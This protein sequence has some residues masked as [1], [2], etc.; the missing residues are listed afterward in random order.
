[1]CEL[2]VLAVVWDCL[3]IGSLILIEASLNPFEFQFQ[4]MKMST[5]EPEILLGHCM[6]SNLPYHICQS[7]PS[8]QPVQIQGNGKIDTT[9]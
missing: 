3:S 4:N 5:T 1:M 6:M 7:K 8:T 2:M 9:S